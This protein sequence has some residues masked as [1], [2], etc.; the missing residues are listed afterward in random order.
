MT[1][2]GIE[3]VLV[4]EFIQ[5]DKRNRH[6]SI[7]VNNDQGPILLTTEQRSACLAERRTTYVPH[8]SDKC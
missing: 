2:L 7:L 3:R 1:Q 5:P 6:S 8:S 4:I